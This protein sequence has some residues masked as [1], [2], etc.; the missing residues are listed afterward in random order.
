MVRKMLVANGVLFR[1]ERGGGGGS[2]VAAH[3]V[4]KQAKLIGQQGLEQ[5]LFCKINGSVS[6]VEMV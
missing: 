3:R 6:N 4:G 5:G 2:G 1:V